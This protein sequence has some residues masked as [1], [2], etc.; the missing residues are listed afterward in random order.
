MRNAVTGLL[1]AGL[2]L[3]LPVTGISA[4]EMTAEKMRSYYAAW[5]AGDV[6]T[7][8]SFFSDDIVYADVPTKA[9]H[10]G[11][12]AVRA[13]VQKFANDYAGVKL[14]AASITIGESSAAVEWI[15]SGGEGAEGEGD[16]Q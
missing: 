2:L 11:N 4:A 6:D 1:V 7:I 9:S 12:A 13:F 16:A 10:A 8:M 5:S 14:S 15:M 3:A